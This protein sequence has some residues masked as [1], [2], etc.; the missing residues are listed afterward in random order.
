MT[1]LKLLFLFGSVA[2]VAAWWAISK[3]R[4]HALLDKA[5]EK[6]ISLEFWKNVFAII[7]AGGVLLFLL[8]WLFSSN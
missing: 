4:E 8:T 5:K 7:G 1:G 3:A 2:S 6:A